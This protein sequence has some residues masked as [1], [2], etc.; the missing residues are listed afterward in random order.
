MKNETKDVFAM[1]RSEEASTTENGAEGFRT[2]GNA[3]LDLSYLIPEFRRGEFHMDLFHEAMNKYPCYTLK[4]LLYLRDIRFGCGERNAFRVFLTELCNK[5]YDT[6]LVFVENIDIEEYGRWDDWLYIYSHCG[7]EA[8]KDIIGNKLSHQLFSDSLPGYTSLL[9]KW[10]PSES[11]HNN[12]KKMLAKEL[13]KK[14]FKLSAPEYR[15]MLSRL[16]KECAPTEVRMSAREWD[17]IDYEQVPSVANLKYK[18]AFCRH[19]AERRNKYLEDLRNGKAKVNTNSAFL[20][21]IVKQYGNCPLYCDNPDTLLE[22][23]WKTQDKIEGFCSTLV[24]RDGSGSMT[25]TI[26]NSD[27]TALNVTD[28]LSIYC[29]EQNTGAWH[30][31][32][33]TFSAEPETIEL[34]DS[35]NLL[36]K[37]KVLHKHTDCSNT[38]IEKT[39]DLLLDVAVKNNLEQ[40]DLPNMLIISDMEFD[41]ATDDYSYSWRH[42]DNTAKNKKL[43]E[44]IAEKF[45]N[46]GY[47][48]PKLIFWNVNS[49]TN[50]IP[51][52]ENDLGVILVSGFNKSILNM[53]I[54]DK[55]DPWEALKDILDIARYSCIDDLFQ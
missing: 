55:N 12:E 22:E 30:N 10:L 33:L 18:N 11:S 29:A 48:L 28:A 41:V 35:M 42:T 16:R 27:V 39:F 6:A 49:R 2:A 20:Y 45:A 9:A 40:E 44:V 4:W 26:G 21:D 24:V 17:K 38:N 23:M 15:K 31:R 52:R 46:H 43:F 54:Q 47:K 5:F 14:Y 25:C 13:R 32:I 34:Q 37:L 53:V 8:I 51:V 19:D 36:D 50:T 3:L 7:N 1:L